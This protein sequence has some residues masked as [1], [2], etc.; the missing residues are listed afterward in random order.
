ME[1]TGREPGIIR[2]SKRP[3]L[4]VLKFMPPNE[5]IVNEDESFFLRS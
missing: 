4:S 3:L 1:G 5:A 2:R